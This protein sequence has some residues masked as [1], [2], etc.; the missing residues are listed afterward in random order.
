MGFLFGMMMIYYTMSS[1]E[2]YF[3][4]KQADLATMLLFNA[5]VSLFYA[6]VA[7]D[8]MVMQN[9]FLFSIIYVWSKLVPDQ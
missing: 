5:L 7:N 4:E 2:A 9:P 6:F 3:G 1:I 8:Y